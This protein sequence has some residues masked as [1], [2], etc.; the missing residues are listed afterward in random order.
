MAYVIVNYWP[1]LA[2]AGGLGF[3]V[4]WWALGSSRRAHSSDGGT[5]P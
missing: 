5:A 3:L 2:A 1:F 4:G